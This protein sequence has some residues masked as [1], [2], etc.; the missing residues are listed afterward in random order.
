MLSYSQRWRTYIFGSSQLL[1]SGAE[2]QGMPGGPWHTLRLAQL[3]AP[4]R[5]Y[6]RERNKKLS[7]PSLIVA[8]SGQ[9]LARLR[10]HHPVLPPAACWLAAQ[11]C[12]HL[13]SWCMLVHFFMISPGPQKSSNNNITQ[14]L[15]LINIS[16][17]SC[18]LYLRP[19]T[20]YIIKPEKVY[21]SYKHNYINFEFFI[22]I[23]A[24]LK[25]QLPYQIYFL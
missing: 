3:A 25:L 6:E 9:F 13:L 2:P 23:T 8:S 20:S 21:C 10:S 14:R 19:L 12:C 22:H 5:V 24:I 18:P 4:A 11:D 1:E 16:L 17:P 7:R 15:I